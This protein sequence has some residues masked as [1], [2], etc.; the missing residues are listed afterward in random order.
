MRSSFSVC[1][2]TFMDILHFLPSLLIL[3]FY[4]FSSFLVRFLHSS[5]F[6]L[7]HFSTLF[8]ILFSFFTFPS[9]LPYFPVI[10]IFVCPSVIHLYQIVSKYLPDIQKSSLDDCATLSAAH[11]Q[12]NITLTAPSSPT[13]STSLSTFYFWA[14]FLRR[15]LWSMTVVKYD[16]RK[17]T[18]PWY[19]PFF[20]SFIACFLSCLILFYFMIYNSSPLVT[21]PPRPFSSPSTGLQE[22][23]SH[24]DT[25][26]T[27]HRS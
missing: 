6:Y 7:P 11:C 14:L 18:Y 8:N 1:P 2:Y 3:L 24:S 9:L 4:F 20:T 26:L 23:M 25:S 27:S 22:C 12:C 21:F 19:F 15:N 17:N 13:P 16:M 5:S 10:F